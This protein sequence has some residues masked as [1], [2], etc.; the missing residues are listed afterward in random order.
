M[1]LERSQGGPAGRTPAIAWGA[2]AALAVLAAGCATTAFE[3]PYGTDPAAVARGEALARRSCG[4][5]HGL[6]SSG[7]SSF[8]GAPPFREL[9]FDYNAISASRQMSQWHEGLA[10]MPPE[11]LSLQDIGFIGAYVRSLKQHRR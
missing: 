8:E 2:I 11:T 7:V 5:C 10:G 1:S 6:G 4:D 9:R 3:G